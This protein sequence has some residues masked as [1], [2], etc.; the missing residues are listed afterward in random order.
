MPLWSSGRMSASQAEDA[1]SILVKGSTLS[2]LSF[3]SISI[4][5]LVTFSLLASIVF[6]PVKAQA[7]APSIRLSVSKAIVETNYLIANNSLSLNYKSEKLASRGRV[8]SF[9]DFSKDNIGNFRYL[10]YGSAQIAKER[11]FLDNYSYSAGSMASIEEELLIGVRDYNLPEDFSLLKEPLYTLEKSAKLSSSLNNILANN[12]WLTDPFMN[13]EISRST[14]AVNKIGKIYTL[15]MD[16]DKRCNSCKF[17]SSKNRALVTRVYKINNDGI[18]T[19]ISQSANKFALEEYG[20]K[21]H[22]ITYN[23]K[24][25]FNS[26]VSITQPTSKILDFDKLLENNEFAI[27]YNTKKVTALLNNLIEGLKSNVTSNKGLDLF[28]EVAK[29]LDAERASIFSY[30]VI[31]NYMQIEFTNASLKGKTIIYCLNANNLLNNELIS[32]GTCSGS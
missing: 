24:F 13:L 4:G 25:N 1:S 7:A 17:F 3:L 26:K 18:I 11:V 21:D 15:V 6:L 14:I 30:K 16:L 12:L 23:I 19:E 9:L 22:T 28:Q 29:L 5:T 2:K 27:N 8:S 31:G 32:I 10:T 20:Y